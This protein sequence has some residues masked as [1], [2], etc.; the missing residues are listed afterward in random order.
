MTTGTIDRRTAPDLAEE[1][2][3]RFGDLL[4]S[5]CRLLGRRPPRE[6]T[7]STSS[8]RSHGTSLLHTL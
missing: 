1:E 4:H 5:R 7:G 3:R 8:S 6:P 2:D